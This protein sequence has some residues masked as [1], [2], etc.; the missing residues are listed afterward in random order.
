MRPTL[1][2]LPLLYEDDSYIITLSEVGTKCV[3]ILRIIRYPRNQNTQGVEENF[4]DLDYMTKRA[5]ID[6]IN[7]RCVGRTV[8]T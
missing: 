6:Q 3:K 5:V 2:D 1:P 7:K 8:M 4:K